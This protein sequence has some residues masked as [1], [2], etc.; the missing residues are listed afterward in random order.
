MVALI[1]SEPPCQTRKSLYLRVCRK[2]SKSRHLRIE[3]NFRLD[4]FIVFARHKIDGIPLIS[5]L[6]RLLPVVEFL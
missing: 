1:I 4:R 2:N 3:A 6:V 5:K